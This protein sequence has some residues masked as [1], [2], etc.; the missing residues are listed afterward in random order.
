MATFTLIGGAPSPTYADLGGLRTT[1]RTLRPQDAAAERRF[2]ESLSPESRHARFLCTLNSVD[3]SLLQQ[4]MAEDADGPLAVVATVPGA[5][6]EDIIGVARLAPTSREAAECAITVADAWQHHGL[7]HR[8]F[9]ALKALARQ[10]HVRR[11]Y[12]VD[13]ASNARMRAFAR[14]LDARVH[15]DPADPTQ[16]VYEVELD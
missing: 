16:V 1:I 13:A 5:E 7:G 8:L 6:G 2:I 10:R 15:A 4:L 12:S 11:L 9:D 3:D 14:S